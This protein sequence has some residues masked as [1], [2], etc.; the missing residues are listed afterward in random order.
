MHQ[1]VN[2]RRWWHQDAWY[3]CEKN[4]PWY[5]HSHAN[6][7]LQSN[8][9]NRQS[10]SCAAY[11]GQSTSVSYLLRIPNHHESNKCLPAGRAGTARRPPSFQVTYVVCLNSHP[12]TKLFLLICFLVFLLQSARE[13]VRSTRFGLRLACRS[14]GCGNLWQPSGDL[15]D[16]R[17]MALDEGETCNAANF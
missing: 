10:F 15:I 17:V 4:T 14:V 2:K 9:G 16:H 12:S 13:C 1:L 5:A 11:S 8:Y 3:N 6:I 7:K